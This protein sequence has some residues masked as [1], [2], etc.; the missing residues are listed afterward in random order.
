MFE[1]AFI[2][3]LKARDIEAGDGE[4]LRRIVATIIDQA[5]K[6]DVAAFREARDTVDGK[7]AQ[8]VLGP[9]DDGEHVLRIE[10]RIT[11]EARR[12]EPRVVADETGA[13]QQLD[14]P[15]VDVAQHLPAPSQLPDVQDK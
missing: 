2:R 5:L 12:P 6:G 7:P 11:G 14:D 13:P 15:H 8:A 4:T 10:H 3:E 9:G 1:Q